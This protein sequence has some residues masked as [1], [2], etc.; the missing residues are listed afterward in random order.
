MKHFVS[1]MNWDQA[2]IHCEAMGPGITLAQPANEAEFQYIVDN[3]Q[4][5]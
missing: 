1:K 3:L 4:F 5:Q 2:I